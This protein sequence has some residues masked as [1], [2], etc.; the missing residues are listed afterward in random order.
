MNEE[1]SN[2]IKFVKY[3]TLYY[4]SI[5]FFSYSHSKVENLQYK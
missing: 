4:L 3:F 1:A 2:Q 5:T